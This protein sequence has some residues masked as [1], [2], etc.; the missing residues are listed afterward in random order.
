V[1]NDVAKNK[2]AEEKRER[3]TTT[4][5][6]PFSYSPVQ[7]PQAIT[8]IK[9]TQRGMT[10]DIGGSGQGGQRQHA[11]QQ[12]REALHSSKQSQKILLCLPFTGGVQDACQ[13][14]FRHPK[15][16]KKSQKTQKKILWIRS[17]NFFL[18]IPNQ[19]HLLFLLEPLLCAA[20]L[21]EALA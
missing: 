11:Q 18:T 15:Q 13:S 3:N 9:H 12:Q 21:V 8:Q 4:T 10:T 19:L 2:L 5:Q 20:V 7:T 14:W 16:K 17:F 1:P 6:I